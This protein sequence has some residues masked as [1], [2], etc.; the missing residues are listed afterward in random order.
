MLA[1]I[2]FTPSCCQNDK[3]PF[4]SFNYFKR[5]QWPAPL[6]IHHLIFF[7]FLL[8]KIVIYLIKG[9]L[10]MPHQQRMMH[11]ISHFEGFF[12]KKIKFWKTFLRMFYALRCLLIYLFWKKKQQTINFLTNVDFKIV[13]VIH[14][15][16][17][18][19]TLL[20]LSL[21][22]INSNNN[23]KKDVGI[24]FLISS[25]IEMNYFMVKI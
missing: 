3:Q 2:Y 5:L 25:E 18:L 23:N 22:W 21:I 4:S 24:F 17:R 16:I 9:E 6:P 13:I 8:K 14:D 20:T 19:R 7:F 1:Y 15:Q 11:S 12:L 10:T